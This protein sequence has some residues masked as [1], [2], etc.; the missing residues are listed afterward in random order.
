M[1]EAACLRKPPRRM[2]NTPNMPAPADTPP[3]PTPPPVGPVLTAGPP[4]TRAPVTWNDLTA[5]LLWPRVFRAA[6][7]AVSPSRLGLAVVMVVLL[8]TSNELCKLMQPSPD[9]GPVWA[10]AAW[11]AGGVALVWT[12]VVWAVW[13]GFSALVAAPM[14]NDGAVAR[15]AA[16]FDPGGE[17]ASWLID[18]PAALLSSQGPALFVGGIAAG[19]IVAVFATAIARSAACE[20]S[21]ELR[22]PWRRALSF[23]LGRARAALVAVVLPLTL[24]WALASGSILLGRLAADALGPLWGEAV[25]M[26]LLVIVGTVAGVVAF[27]Y[28]LGAGLLIS[29]VAADGAD[30][31][32]AIQRAYAYVL[33][34]PGRLVI[35]GSL[36][37][38]Q[39]WV[40]A[41][42]VGL[43]LGSGL[44]VAA[45][46]MGVAAPSPDARG[47]VLAPLDA[48]A[49]PW[50][51]GAGAGADR[52]LPSGGDA[53]A[54]AVTSP[55]RG[56]T[57]LSAA[58][59]AKEGPAGTPPR[60]WAAS[61]TAV[62]V[63]ADLLRGLGVAVGFSLSICGWTIIYLLLRQ[64]VDGQDADELWLEPERDLLGAAAPGGSSPAA[65]A[66]SAPAPAGPPGAA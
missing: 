15:L 43:L 64:L 2:T 61:G 23:G 39:V 55:A 66:V 14:L 47:P 65:G 32:D 40:V 44:S 4:V 33:G 5:G 41:S 35:Y 30:G 17:L 52:W 12:V 58:E 21:A 16:G 8:A 1:P 60:S 48:G 3:G 22:L 6:W 62:S 54:G 34:R 37:R 51:A 25:A 57:S 49:F 28:A 53:V 24:A 27:V 63:A 36:L 19:L 56:L 45:R 9:A 29:A 26:P 13:I 46:P 59:M 20:S 10:L 42:V 7:L 31:M 38:A 18:Q 50:A 11:F